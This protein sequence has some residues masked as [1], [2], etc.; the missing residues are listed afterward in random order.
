MKKGYRFL[1]LSGFMASS[2]L[3]CSLA[4]SVSATSSDDFKLDYARFKGGIPLSSGP[5]TITR[6]E[7][8]VQGSE[9]VVAGTLRRPHQV[10]FPGFL[11]L[12]IRSPERE[13]LWEEK[14]RIPGLLSHRNGMLEVPFR[15]KLER[16]PPKGVVVS[17]CYL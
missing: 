17:L 4:P 15:I 14:H 9:L 5:V 8:I 16:L 6:A 12:V 13:L 10:H 11:R 2:I 7:I 1:L 3:G